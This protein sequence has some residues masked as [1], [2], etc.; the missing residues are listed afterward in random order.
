MS[1]AAVQAVV[2][3][4]DRSHAAVQAVLPSPAR[5]DVAVQAALPDPPKPAVQAAAHS[6]T[7]VQADLLP[8]RPVQDLCLALGGDQQH[9]MDMFCTDSDYFGPTRK[10]REEERRKERQEDLDKIKRMMEKF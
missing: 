2:S 1:D 6:A 5:A 8:V 3:S 10:Q 9:V 7:A 4:P